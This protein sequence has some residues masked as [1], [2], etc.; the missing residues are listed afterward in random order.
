MPD[1]SQTLYLLGEIKGG[2]DAMKD[3]L[4][5][6]REHQDD[7]RASTERIE[8]TQALFGERLDGHMR[9]DDRRFDD[10]RTDIDRAHAKAT[11]AQHSGGL[12]KSQKRTLFGGIGAGL[13]A[14]GW[15]IANHLKG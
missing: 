7:L 6:I 2:Q 1:D 4:V 11:K 10:H 12:S 15:W 13:S 5:V 14:A 3:E 8:S 9:D